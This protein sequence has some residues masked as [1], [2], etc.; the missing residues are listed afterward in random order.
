MNKY[1]LNN[2]LHQKNL[3]QVY[4]ENIQLFVDN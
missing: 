1:I 4:E 3:D 2:N